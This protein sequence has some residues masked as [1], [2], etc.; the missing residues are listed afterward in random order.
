MGSI[1][2]EPDDL[3]QSDSAFYEVEGIGY[4]FIP[5]VCERRV[6]IRTVTH[7]ALVCV[8]FS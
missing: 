5:T 2:A 3:N 1:I 7:L 8:F 4:D 6:S